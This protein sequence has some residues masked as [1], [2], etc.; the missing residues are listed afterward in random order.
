MPPK[1]KEQEL[2]EA[3]VQGP[4][5]RQ[6]RKFS[7]AEPSKLEFSPVRVPDSESETPKRSVAAVEAQ[8]RPIRPKSLKPEQADEFG[9]QSNDDEPEEDARSGSD[10]RTRS[11]PSEGEDGEI[12]AEDE[13][14]SG[15]EWVGGI[16]S[17]GEDYDDGID[18]SRAIE[19]DVD[20]RTEEQMD[21][22][23]REVAFFAIKDRMKKEE[24]YSDYSP[25]PSDVDE[26]LNR[27]I[28]SPGPGLDAGY[29]SDYYEYKKG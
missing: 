20:P 29:G 17:Y 3:D 18:P 22:D 28:N 13:E 24:G 15:E 23:L 10:S 1:R 14:S 26:E 19:Y 27:M 4:S 12:E 11:E 7:S 6:R 2:Q 8:D 21:E 25:T 9:T 16:A 5:N